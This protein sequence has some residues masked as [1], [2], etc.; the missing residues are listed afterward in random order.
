MCRIG[1]KN[2]VVARAIRKEKDVHGDSC[3]YPSVLRGG[4]CNVAGGDGRTVS[5]GPPLPR[6]WRSPPSV[7]WARL[8]G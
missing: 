7:S 1:E 4:A 2:F 8:N 5:N 3:Y 6:L